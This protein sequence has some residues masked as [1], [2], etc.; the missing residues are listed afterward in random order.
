[1]LGVVGPAR[2]DDFILERVATGLSR[3]VFATS[4]PGDATRLFIVEQF[5]GNT[6]R[7]RILRLATGELLATPFLS[8]VGVSTGNEQGLLGLAFH[9]DYA[10]NG[11]FYVNFTNATGTTVIRRYSED[12]DPDRA[13][14]ASATAV[15]EIGQPQGNHNGGWIGFGPDGFLYV[16]T[17]DGGGSN[18]NDGGHTAG[19]GNSQ[20][21]TENLLG[22]VLRI[23]VDGDDFPQDP[24]RNYAIPADNPFVGG[25]GDD[26]IWLYGLRHPWRLSFD[27]ETGDLYIGDVGQ[28]SREEIDVQPAGRP[29]GTNYG[30]RLREG[31]IATPGEGVGGP[32]PPGAVD[33]IYEYLHG[34]GDTQGFAVTGG[35]VYRGPALS[36]RGRYLFADYLTSRIWS[37]RWDGSDPLDFDGTNFSEFVDWGDSPSFQPDQGTLAEISS[38]GEDAQGNLYI[39]SLLGDVFRVTALPPPVPALAP[40]AAGLLVGALAACGGLLARRRRPSS[41]AA[42]GP[43]P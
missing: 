33:P 21:T 31:T 28:G 11:H 2:A 36:L 13:D 37:L 15:L 19:I 32:R 17:G 25:P 38:F 18:D 34:T 26:E 42:G 27:R 16:A 30:W 23:D 3:P 22:K 43:G 41:P 4:P 10:S 35:V 12:T 5:S 7:V 39:A 8:L 40:A 29:G 6:G 1:V 9:P 24:D 20:D 14:P